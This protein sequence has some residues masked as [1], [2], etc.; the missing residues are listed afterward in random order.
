L[1]DLRPEKLARQRGRAPCS[2]LL[3]GFGGNS[4]LSELEDGPAILAS[5]RLNSS[6]VG[7]NTM[8]AAELEAVRSAARLRHRRII[9]L[10][11]EFQAR[12]G[13]SATSG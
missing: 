6:N 3:C 7:L 5:I 11:N 2:D 12:N 1:A 8:L 13:G 10:H 4:E 9:Y